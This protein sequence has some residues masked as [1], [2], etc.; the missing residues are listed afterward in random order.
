MTCY[1]Y[2]M[3]TCSKSATRFVWEHHFHQSEYPSITKL[4]SLIDD[5]DCRNRRIH[6]FKLLHHIFPQLSLQNLSFRAQS[7]RMAAVKQLSEKRIKVVRARN[8]N[9][10]CRILTAQSYYHREIGHERHRHR[11]WQQDNSTKLRPRTTLSLS[12]SERLHLFQ[13]HPDNWIQSC[14]TSM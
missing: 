2:I 10:G 11:Q 5:R 8:R 3:Y 4:Y 6:L 12:I 7:I 13:G 14:S 9:N 1:D